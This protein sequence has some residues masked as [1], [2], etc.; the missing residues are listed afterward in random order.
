[1]EEGLLTQWLEQARGFAFHS[2]S[3]SLLQWSLW[4]GVVPPQSIF[5]L[6]IYYPGLPWEFGGRRGAKREGST[7]LEREVERR[8]YHW[9]VLWNPGAPP[10]G[11]APWRL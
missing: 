6:L 2:R 5:I 11:S 7:S 4:S 1:M 8:N 9:G 10:P 3:A